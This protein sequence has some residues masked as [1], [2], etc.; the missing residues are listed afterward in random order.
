MDGTTAG[1]PGL[2]QENGWTM[3]RTEDNITDLPPSNGNTCILVIVDRFSKSCR[4]LPLKGHAL[5]RSESGG[6]LAKG[7]L[8]VLGPGSKSSGGRRFVRIGL[9]PVLSSPSARWSVDGNQRRDLRS[10]SGGKRRPSRRGK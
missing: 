9:S 3:R 2:V 1:N 7:V 5:E 8:C 6:W 4:L 10:H